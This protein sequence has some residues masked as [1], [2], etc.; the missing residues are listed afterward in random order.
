MG[1]AY[2]KREEGLPA[3]MVPVIVFACVFSLILASLVVTTTAS[4]AHGADPNTVYINTNAS[5]R[6]GTCVLGN[7]SYGVSGNTCSLGAALTLT[8]AS[9]TP[10]TITLATGFAASIP[11][12]TTMMITPSTTSS[13]WMN[14]TH[15]NENNGR[16]GV[17]AITAPVTIDLRGKLG[18]NPIASTP[19]SILVTG[20]SVTLNNMSEIRG[21][22]ASIVIS[23][24]ARNVTL[25]GGTTMPTS[26]LLTKRFLEIHN[27]AQGVTF[28]NYTV[29][30]LS[31]RTDLWAAAVFFAYM[32]IT[33]TTTNVV[34]DNVTFTTTRP[35][36]SPTYSCTD[37]DSSS[38]A[39]IAISMDDETRITNLEIKNSTFKN[40]R[41][42]PAG[43]H[44]NVLT[45]AGAGFTVYLANLDFHD[46]QI[47][48]TQSCTNNSYLNCALIYLPMIGVSNTVKSYIRNNTFLN[49]PGVPQPHA[50]AWDAYRT[51]N[52]NTTSSG[53]HILDNSFDGFTGSTIALADAGLVTMERNLFGPN[54]ASQANTIDE[55]TAATAGGQ[56][57]S[58]ITKALI[59]NGNGDMATNKKSLTWYPTGA[60]VDDV[61]CEATLT[62]VAPTNSNA[63]RIPPLPVR[64]EVYYT[65]T[66]KA[67]IYLDSQQ[68]NAGS[69]MQITVPI[70]SQ[71]VGPGGILAGGMRV[72]TQSLAYSQPMTSQ[73]SRV[74]PLVGTCV[75][76]E[77]TAIA[78]SSGVVEG[79][80]T[81]TITGS[82]FAH[83]DLVEAIFNGGDVCTS[84]T[85]MSDTEATCE[86]P[87]STRTGSLTGE[88]PLTVTLT[89]ENLV[90]DTFATSYT[91]VAPGELT[92]IK[93][94]WID[95]PEVAPEALYDTLIATGHGG[96]TEILSGSILPLETQVTWTYTVVYT[97]L[98][99]GLPYGTANDLALTLVVVTDDQL[100]EVCTLA[101]VG[102]NAPVGCTGT[103]LVTARSR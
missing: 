33:Q 38:C 100:G 76:V 35:V 25:N 99:G 20:S 65:A 5:G 6:T 62:I 36:D 92:I 72:L 64:L 97:Y 81:L 13:T 55:E 53:L 84:M 52:Y 46:N 14:T 50:I 12:G 34:I 37:L 43:A 75:P 61:A 18:I 83:V 86:I 39:N 57:S 88:I 47:I 74:V 28:S 21:Y 26:G 56:N 27:G 8:N 54:T 7:D 22:M 45:T 10:R 15:V 60:T 63:N 80:N 102:L 85:V 93:R 48:D 67:E 95:V 79:G 77:T 69:T 11:D 42:D 68:V 51:T 71:A 59:M 31:D 29:G 90:I 23:T 66:T 78:P 73:F 98:V 30:N 103:S 87:A 2:G 101:S 16:G 17:Y 9:A 40:L 70:P 89:L 19:A 4:R 49:S 82:G 24:T 41:E 1:F 91:Y 96:A 58:T 44:P 94:A 3:W 32:N